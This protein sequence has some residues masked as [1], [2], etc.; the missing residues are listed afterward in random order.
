MNRFIEHPQVVITIKY[1]IVTDFHTTT[2]ST[3][4][5]SVYFH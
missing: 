2:H 3:L 1:N 5:F 4:I